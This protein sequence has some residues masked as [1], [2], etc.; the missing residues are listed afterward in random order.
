[1]VQIVQ[2]PVNRRGPPPR[3][4]V[5]HLAIGESAFFAGISANKIGNA[6]RHHKDMKFRCKTVVRGGVEG[7]RVWRIA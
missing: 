7:A 2:V 1:M 3:Y 5:R 4:P 6:V